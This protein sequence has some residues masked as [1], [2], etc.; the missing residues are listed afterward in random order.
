MAPG[1]QDGICPGDRASQETQLIEYLN[2][3]QLPVAAGAAAGQASC[4]E[5]DAS[6]W[7]IGPLDAHPPTWLVRPRHN[8][9]GQIIEDQIPLAGADHNNQVVFA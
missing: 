2:K 4:L 5:M 6:I 8:L 7:V 1:G 3:E 9:V